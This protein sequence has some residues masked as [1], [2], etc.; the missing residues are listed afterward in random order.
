[1]TLSDISFVVLALSNIVLCVVAV[2]AE[3][4]ATIKHK[5]W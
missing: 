1:M 4:R 5:T 3:I 2:R